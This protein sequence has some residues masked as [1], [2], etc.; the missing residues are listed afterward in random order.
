[1]LEG[2]SFPP[3]G[4]PSNPETEPVSPALAG[5][6]FTTEP[7]KVSLHPTSWFGGKVD[8]FAYGA[9][10]PAENERIMTQTPSH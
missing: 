3:P 8:R 9:Q 10:R 5:R 6:L 4:D 7:P 1:M 2:L